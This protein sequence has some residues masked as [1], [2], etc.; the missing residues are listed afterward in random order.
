M[1]KLLLEV[2]RSIVMQNPLIKDCLKWGITPKDKGR[3]LNKIPGETEFIT[4]LFEWH[5]G[6]D[7]LRWKTISENGDMV[8]HFSYKDLTFIPG[9]LGVFYDIEYFYAAFKGWFELSKYKPA[10]KEAIHRYFPILSVDLHYS[11][12]VDVAEGMNSRIVF[13]G[14][15][16]NQPIFLEAYASPQEFLVDLIRVNQS[17]DGELLFFQKN[18]IPR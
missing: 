17:N 18:I 5:N 13:C 11:F 3:Y 15:P 10:Y 8:N 9:R 6:V 7:P 4:T 2:E 12:A 16:R 14:F 1:N